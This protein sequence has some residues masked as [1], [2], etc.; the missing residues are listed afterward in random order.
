MINF[1]ASLIGIDADEYDCNPETW[2]SEDLDDDDED[3]QAN[4]SHDRAG[5][6]LLA[7]AI[8]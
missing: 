8:A 5:A 3:Y 4:V 7:V 2:E 6:F 1:L